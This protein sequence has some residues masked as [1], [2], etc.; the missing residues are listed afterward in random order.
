M[1]VIVLTANGYFWDE[2][3]DLKRVL[4]W[5]LKDKIEV[6][7]YDENH[8]YQSAGDFG[9]EG[10]VI[11]I[12]IPL[13]VRFMEFAGCKIKDEII[14]YSSDAVYDRDRD[15][16]QYYHDYVLNDEGDAIPCAPYKYRCTE[17]EK[18][19]DHIVPI[20]MGGKTSFLNCVCCC[21]YCNELIKRNHLPRE[22][23]MRLIRQPFVPT[24]RVGEMWMP[25]FTYNPHKEAH[26][27]FYELMGWEFSHKA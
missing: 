22:A 27:A 6:L 26:R 1:S 5:M 20:S 12:K 16:C 11:R 14:G 7:K 15:V 23:G 19:I 17:D 25:K 2:V 21:K 13:V 10:T 9:R 24:R 4:K 3:S 8:V 18:S